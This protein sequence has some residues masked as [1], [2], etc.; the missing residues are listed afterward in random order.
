[1][2]PG[3][4]VRLVRS[5]GRYGVGEEATVVDL[6]RGLV[7]G[8]DLAATFGNGVTLCLQAD[9]VEVVEP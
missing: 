6:P 8:L 5:I 3:T 4:R 9:E 7:N 2:I 1:M